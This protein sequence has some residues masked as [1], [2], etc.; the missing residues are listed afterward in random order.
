[1]ITRF[2]TNLEDFLEP[3]KVLVIF[4]SRQVG[5]TTLIKE[6]LKNTEYKYKFDIGDNIKTQEVL[7][8]QD[9]GKIQAYCEGYELIII[10]EAQRI[11]NIG[12]GLK[13][14]VDT[15]PNIR[16]IVTVDYK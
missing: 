8:S 11:P 10:D 5:K 13:I 4:G 6:F 3:N 16:V 14:I 2:Y 12:Y 15:I 7:S 9:V 1:M